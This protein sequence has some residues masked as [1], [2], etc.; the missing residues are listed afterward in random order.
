VKLPAAKNGF[1]LLPRR[2]VVERRF[3][4]ASRF[5]RLARDDEQL[6]ITLAGFHGLAFA[7]LW[8]RCFGALTVQRG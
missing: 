2:W 4:Q 5:R 8:L 3:A 1:E 7:T 6:P